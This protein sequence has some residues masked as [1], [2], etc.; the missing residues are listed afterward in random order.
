MTTG[1]AILGIGASG[2]AAARLALHQGEDVHVSDLATHP[3]AH[4]AAGELR[5]LG[6]HVELGTHDVARIARAGTV[7][8]SPGI[9]PDAPVLRA[10]RG[11]G[12]R[13]IGEPEYAARFLPGTL[14]AVTGTNGKTTTV[15]LTAH[16]LRSSGVDAEAGGNVGGGLA[17]AASALA[18]RE[19]PPA[20]VVLEMSSFQLADTEDFAPDVGVVTNLA[21]DHLDRYPDV[22]TYWA[23]K[24][25]LFRNATS[26]SRWIL[27]GES[28]EVRALPGAA[29]GLRLLFALDRDAVAPPDPAR[30]V[31]AAW[32]DD[33]I[34]TLRIPRAAGGRGEVEPLL[35]VAAL[36]VLGRHNLANALA[37]ALAARLAGATVEGLRTG[38]ATAE[39]LPHRMEP[40]AEREGVLW[41]NDS[42]ATNVAAAR[43]AVE[44]LDRPLVLLVGGKD[45]GEPF[46]P[47][48]EVLPGRV[49]TVLAF[50]E[51]GPRIATE[52][53]VALARA[54][55]GCEEGVAF[56]R[57]AA[58]EGAV[59]RAREL[60]VPGD[61]VLLA[62]ACSSFDAF[63]DFAARGDR[64]RALAA[65]EGA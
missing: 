61:V 24:A 64:F 8:V 58:L 51:A 44:S 28:P 55:G 4:A 11:A 48:A 65:G 50:G 26:R 27:N 20:V 15:L 60:A 57:I 47:L 34:L 10:L 46:A 19:P 62:P 9:P 32:I 16:L 63:R 23:D 14:T 5:E 43:T 40:V 6:A 35:P 30:E 18:L 12:V 22:A 25:R 37:A 36:P 21:P 3:S 56:E 41:V 7:I 33:G 45:K 13:W 42:K 53:Q 29:P 17:P 54:G 49:R 38:L 52:L 59:T 2:Q 31:L 39:P 1:V